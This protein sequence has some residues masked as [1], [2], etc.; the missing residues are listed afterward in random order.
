MIKR[1]LFL[2]L[3]LVVI[4]VGKAQDIPVIDSPCIFRFVPGRDMFYIPYKRNA[5]AFERLLGSIERYREDI[6][7]GKITVLVD[8][9]C[10]DPNIAKTRSNRVKTEM[11]LKGG[12]ME[13]CFNTVN[14]REKGDY[15][16]VTISPLLI[17]ERQERM[18]DESTD[19][20]TPLTDIAN[21][22]N[23]ADATPAVVATANP[24]PSPIR[25]GTGNTFFVRTD[26]LRWATLTADLGVE[27][28]IRD[29][30]GILI[31]GT[32]ANWGWRNK[33]RRYKVWAV[34]PQV[35][36]YAG[37]EKRGFI[38]VMYH[39]GEFNYKLGGTGHT[40]D[41]QGG[42][43]TGGYLLPLTGALRLEFQGALGYT[44]AGYEKYARIGEVNVRR[45]SEVKNYWGVNQLDVSLVWKW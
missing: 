7:S 12:L 1:P 44:R 28:R 45:G 37:K 41:Y 23:K 33:T 36:Y 34:S 31:N 29:T 25:R 43:I 3:L 9:Y 11:I 13:Q 27:Y 20:E 10:T 14:H 32:F 22:V 6:L 19:T 8:G 17:K 16:K 30:W 35:R 42:G 38:G 39:I 15:V 5:K 2:L 21:I 4:S 18:A 26:L 24:N 40:G